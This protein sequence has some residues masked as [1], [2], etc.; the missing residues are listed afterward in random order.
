M[1][2]RDIDDS[3]LANNIIITII[4]FVFIWMTRSVLKY[5]QT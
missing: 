2:A 5:P 4:V 1:L 3:M